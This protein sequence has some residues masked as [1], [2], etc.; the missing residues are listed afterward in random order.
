MIEIKPIGLEQLNTY[1]MAVTERDDVYG[2]VDLYLQGEQGF[3][4]NLRATE[5]LDAALSYGLGKAVLNMADLKGAK[6][7]SCADPG[8]ESFLSPLGFT[9]AE[10]SL[11][12]LSLKH[13]FEAGCHAKSEEL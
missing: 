9:K 11:W 7:V 4:S 12:T 3:L 5:E 13:Y 2:S 1:R 6:T 10:D 8:M